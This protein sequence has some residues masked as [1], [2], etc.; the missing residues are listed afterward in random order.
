MSDSVGKY[1]ELE[2]VG[3]PSLRLEGHALEDSALP[4]HTAEP[5]LNSIRDNS[6]LCERSA[7]GNRE[8]WWSILM[9]VV[10]DNSVLKCN[11]RN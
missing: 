1:I 5:H 2:T 10:C 4:S 9:H 8:K 6:L 3:R 11:R 7:L